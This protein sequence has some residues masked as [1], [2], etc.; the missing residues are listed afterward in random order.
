MLLFIGQPC[1]KGDRDGASVKVLGSRK[2]TLVEAERAVIRLKVDGNVMQI[3]TN[4]VSA[5]RLKYFTVAGRII[6]P[7]DLEMP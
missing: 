1:M 7:D 6:Q 5:Q 4:P 3:H 2:I